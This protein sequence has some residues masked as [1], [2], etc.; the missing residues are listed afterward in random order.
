[1]PIRRS[2]GLVSLGLLGSCLVA[3]GDTSSPS[4]GSVPSDAPASDAGSVTQV[5]FDPSTEAMDFGDI[6]FPDDL[7][8]NAAGGV[9]LA[10]LPSR[11]QS[12]DVRYGPLLIESLTQIDGFGANSPVFFRIDGALSGSSLPDTPTAATAES[13]SVFLMDI[14]SA[15]PTRGRRLPAEVRWVAA[16]STLA[17]RPFDGA[18]LVEGRAYAA[19]VTRRVLD[20]A[21]LPLGPSPAFAAVRDAT[22]RPTDPALA[23]AFDEHD[24][25]L[26]MLSASGV[27]RSDV[28]GLAVFH[29]Q[30]IT[31]DL[32]AIRTQLRATPR[33]AP[34][35]ER[36]LA[37]GAGLDGL[38][39]TPTGT[40]PGV[41]NEGGVIHS[42][43][44][45]VV[46]GTFPAPN[47]M[48][49][50]EH[51]HGAFTRTADG[52]EV[53]RTD[54]VWFTLVLPAGTT[55]DLPLVV[56]QH[57]FGQS[58]ADIF[59][60]ADTLCEQGYA[61]AAI[62]I[63]WHGMR[64]DTDAPDRRHNFVSGELTADLYG[65]LA[66]P[67]IYLDY[68]GVIDTRGSLAPFHPFYTRD[69]FRQS[70]SD[71]LALVDLIEDTD[72]T[73][74]LTSMG[75]PTAT[76]FDDA[77]PIGFVG[78]SLGGILG[79]MFVTTEVR[80][81]AA[82]LNVTGG[83]LSRL[84]SGSAGFSGAF[85][86]LL[87]PR[88]GAPDYESIDYDVEPPWMFPEVALFQTLLDRGDSMGYAPLLARQNK[89]VLFQMA[90]DDETVPNVATEALALASNANIMDADPHYAGL[91]R[92]TGPV[93][94]NVAVDGGSVTRALAVF[95]PA[96]HGSVV[97]QRGAYGYEHPPDPPFVG[98]AT[99]TPIANPIVPMQQ[100]IL[101]FFES[102]RAGNAEVRAPD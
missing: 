22:S 76:S 57:G 83:H 84:V 102:W 25:V 27:A 73:A 81:G 60:I 5:H 28:V 21:G 59:A 19:V 79:T 55:T 46:D 97:A 75:G 99:P 36:V 44:G 54:D 30:T 90:L 52:F 15:S 85:L 37:A 77:A 100:Q 38:L 56:F 9:V 101:R 6:P 16:S 40:M 45:Y 49:A 72:W 35:I 3:C 17:V 14:D 61:V 87:L 63:P 10:S 89:H 95:T 86:P 78:Q 11:A 18:P 29:V 67:G 32:T 96:T 65:D 23:R 70:V 26:A 91:T 48:N 62:D 82:A 88:L 42:H 58:R 7:Y 94:A 39:G 20:A 68:I 4:D 31:A 34:T 24:T 66:S 80:V 1:M 69:A 50:T 47:F 64:A 93:R 12:S 98:L 8:R 53:K 2:F 71:E 33:A 43:I 74:A 13:A 41:D 51:V 92:V